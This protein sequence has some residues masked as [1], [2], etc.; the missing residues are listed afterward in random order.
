MRNASCPHEAE[1]L[2]VL[3]TSRW[4]DAC[5]DA[6]RRHVESCDGCNELVSLSLALLDDQ[7]ALMREAP[8]PSS[9]IVWWRAQMRSR[10]EAAEQVAQ[11]ITVIQGLAGACAAGLLVAAAGYYIP[12]LRR[13]VEWVT[14]IVATA[15]APGSTSLVALEPL[16]VGIEAAI[17]L[18]LIVAPLALYFTFREDS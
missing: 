17:F 13:A 9:A 14:T 12:A 18:A 3:Q 7:R 2:D 15:T 5:G 6:L 10:R 16:A 11:P 8:V 1:V 4:P